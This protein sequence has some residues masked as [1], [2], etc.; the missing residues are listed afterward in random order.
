MRWLRLCSVGIVAAGLLGCEPPAVGPRPR[1][2]LLVLLTDFGSRDYYVGAAKGAAYRASSRVR[3]ETIT[4]E[5]A[6]FDVREGA[7]TL[8]LAAREFPQGTVFVGVVDPGVGTG[9]RAIA[10][11]TGAGHTYVAPDN[12]LL[13]LVAANE[14]VAEVRDITAFRPLGRVPSQT[15][16][17]RDLFVPTG[18][19]LAAGMPMDR[20]GPELPGIKALAFPKPLLDRGVLKGM[21]MR[22]DRYGNVVTNIPAALVQQAGI[23]PGSIVLI[24]LGGRKELATFATT[25]GSVGKGEALCLLDS[26][27]QLELA[28]NTGS[29]AERL[30]AKAGQSVAVRKRR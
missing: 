23:A 5:I 24:D 7:V 27:G 11:R 18:A 9:R 13:T 25:Y 26:F 28:V 4:H 30:K 16:Q 19:L 8:S 10:L 1:Q 21:V 15:F 3:I 17:G 20:L 6:P 14:G 2:E 12:G 22:I 29:M